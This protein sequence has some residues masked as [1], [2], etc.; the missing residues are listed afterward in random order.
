MTIQAIEEY[1]VEEFLGEIQKDLK[2]GEYWPPPV[3]RHYIPKPDGKQRPLGIPTVRDRVV[4]T[5]VKLVI[6]P[7]FEADFEE[8]SYGF[9]PKRGAQD[10]LDAIRKAGNA[11][12]DWVV[13][14][15]IEK[16][17]DSIDHELL[18]KAVQKRVTDPKVLK[19]IRRWL[20]AGVME[21][22]VVTEPERGT[23][24]GGVISPLLSNIYLGDLDRTWR[25]LQGGPGDDPDSVRGR[26]CGDVSHGGEGEGGEGCSRS[27]PK[28]AE[29]QIASRQDAS[30]QPGQERRD[31]HVPR[32]HAQEGAV[33]S[34]WKEE[35]PLPLAQPSERQQHP[36]ASEGRNRPPPVLRDESADRPC[37]TSPGSDG[38]G[39]VLPNGQRLGHLREGGT[40][41]LVSDQST[42]SPSQS[43]G[44]SPLDVL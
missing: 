34:I 30:G 13:D 28:E 4:Q 12:H 14:A 44:V 10:A 16:Y 29:A 33:A 9:R 19:L 7:L 11:G 3:R 43:T 21:S 17:F 39:G 24:Q 20:K 6:E 5:A 37:G 40:L 32:M 31:V 15:D 1:G 36:G 38:V 35:V 23:P 41:R 25:S 42:S 27:D 26:L 8:C 22:G 18:M 2:A